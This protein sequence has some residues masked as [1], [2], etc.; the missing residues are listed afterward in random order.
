MTKKEK[1]CTHLES[2]QSHRLAQLIIEQTEKELR[3][4]TDR[5]K[6]VPAPSGSVMIF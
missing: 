4:G 5:K 2:H 1:K 3:R 6:R